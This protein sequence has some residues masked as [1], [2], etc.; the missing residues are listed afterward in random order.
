M[1]APSLSDP[2]TA[3]IAAAAAAGVTITADLSGYSIILLASV[4]GAMYA[5][6][7]DEKP[8]TRAAAAAFVLGRVGLTVLLG[9]LIAKVAT[10]M[11]GF[12]WRWLVGPLAGFVAAVG[13]QWFIEQVKSL[14]QRRT[15]A[16]P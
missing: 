7:S 11:S 4:G 12:D 13:P 14:W 6:I 3:L 16:Q 2:V 1:T 5:L 9:G 10:Q 15:G 8:R